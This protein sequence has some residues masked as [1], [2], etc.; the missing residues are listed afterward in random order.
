MS[1]LSKI[2]SFI[3]RIFKRKE[4]GL[5]LLI[6][7]EIDVIFNHYNG[8]INYIQKADGYKLIYDLDECKDILPRVKN[9]KKILKGMIG[10]T[11]TTTNYIYL[12]PNRIRKYTKA[13]YETDRDSISVIINYIVLHELSHLN[14]DFNMNKDKVIMEYSND[15]NLLEFINNVIIY[16]YD[17]KED[18]MVIDPKKF[19]MLKSTITSNLQLLSETGSIYGDPDNSEFTFITSRG[20]E[21]YLNTRLNSL[22]SGYRTSC[23]LLQFI[24]N[25]SIA[26]V[27]NNTPRLNELM[28]SYKIIAFGK[29]LDKNTIDV[30]E[31]YRD[32]KFVMSDSDIYNLINRLYEEVYT[33]SGSYLAIYNDEENKDELDIV[34]ARKEVLK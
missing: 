16:F 6:K 22:Y 12:F 25:N 28:T 14:Q 32:G 1:I 15:C 13:L 20:L 23:M 2:K 29:M 4:D 24:I 18:K 7:K 26:N 8:S 10:F 27:V 21:H 30:D 3:K 5:D 9:S 34:L 11:S 33:E 31:I 17:Y 19:D